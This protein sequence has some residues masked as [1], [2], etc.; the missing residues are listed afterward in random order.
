ME[1]LV[2]GVKGSQIS[3]PCLVWVFCDTPTILVD[4]ADMS[5]RSF[6]LSDYFD[7]DYSYLLEPPVT[8]NPNATGI[9]KVTVV[10]NCS[11][12]EFERFR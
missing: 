2:Q 4:F 7:G 11:A 12:E 1:E 6:D 8:V 3:F 10:K 5:G 9:G